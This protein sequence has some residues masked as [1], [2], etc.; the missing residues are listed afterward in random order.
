MGK[1]KQKRAAN[2][3]KGKQQ[4][5]K[6]YGNN[7]KFSTQADSTGP[8]KDDECVFSLYRRYKEAT[9]RAKTVMCSLAP[10][11]FKYDLVQNFV[12]AADFIVEKGTVLVLKALFFLGVTTG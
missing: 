8:T 1:G 3:K 5:Q 9:Q 10:N 2:K 11:K 7:P 12:D 6:Q 4:Q